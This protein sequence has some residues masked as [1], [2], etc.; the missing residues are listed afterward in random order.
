MISKY[1]R[2]M[3]RSLEKEQQPGMTGGP[4]GGRARG[5]TSSPATTGITPMLERSFTD[6][7][8]GGGGASVAQRRFST[9]PHPAGALSPLDCGSSTRDRVGGPE[10]PAGRQSGTKA[11]RPVAAATEKKRRPLSPSS[12]QAGGHI[13][14]RSKSVTEEAGVK[15]SSSDKAF[16]EPPWE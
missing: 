13:I 5:T 2:Y 14:K 8:S 15:G 3:Q 4:A 7:V 1:F 12:S 11:S 16:E 9:K 10:H 6:V